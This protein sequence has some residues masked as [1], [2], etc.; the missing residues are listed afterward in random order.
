MGTSTISV[1][2]S[3]AMCPNFFLNKFDSL[4]S[5]TRCQHSIVRR[6]STAALS[7]REPS[8]VFR[9]RSCFDLVMQPVTDSA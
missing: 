8:R 6:R 9:F 3:E 2:R 5:E 1:P 4:Q 7:G